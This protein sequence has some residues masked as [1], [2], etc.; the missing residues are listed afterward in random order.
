MRVLSNTDKQLLVKKYKEKIIDGTALA[1]KIRLTL[2]QRIIDIN[3]RYNNDNVNLRR[4][5]LGHII[6]G[7]LPASEMYV[8]LK[9]KACDEIGIGHYG[10]KLSSEANENDLL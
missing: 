5:W 10:F 3:Q 7:D 4:P 8:R 1:K 9:L 6:V 2:K